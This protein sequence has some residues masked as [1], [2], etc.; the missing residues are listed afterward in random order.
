MRCKR[1]ALQPAVGTAVGSSLTSGTSSGSR[2]CGCVRWCTPHPAAGS[3]GCSAA[4]VPT[5]PAG[6]RGAHLA[7][8]RHI[9]RLAAVAAGVAAGGYCSMF[10]RVGNINPAYLPRQQRGTH[11]GG[12]YEQGQQL[13]ERRGPDG[14]PHSV[15]S[16]QH[17]T[18]QQRSRQTRPA[19]AGGSRAVRQ[20]RRWP[21]NGAAVLQF[22]LRGELLPCMV[23]PQA[24][25]ASRAWAARQA[26]V[27]QLQRVRQLG[28][29]HLALSVDWRHV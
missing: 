9:P 26:R 5:H 23:A 7:S 22:R 1:Q 12:R 21:T 19:Q 8:I 10:A 20:P 17:P 13:A 18:W 11:G 28:N 29:C 3:L 27:R 2:W 25:R 15:K 6:R 4:W 14:V 24:C 16:T